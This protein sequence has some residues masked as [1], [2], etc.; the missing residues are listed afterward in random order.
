MKYFEAAR[1][2]QKRTEEAEKLLT[3]FAGYAKPA[4]FLKKRVHEFEPVGKEDL[5]SVVEINPGT[6]MIALVDSEGNAKAI[7]SYIGKIRAQEVIKQIEEAGIRKYDGD[8][9]L[10]E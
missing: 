7:S 8:L 4:I 5:F 1:E 10:P 6:V 3:R 2:G 9:N